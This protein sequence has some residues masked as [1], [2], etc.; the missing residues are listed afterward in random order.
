MKKTLLVIF[1]FFFDN[2]I[3]L[4]WRT[5]KI[6]DDWEE[7]TRTLIFSDTI[8]PNKPLDFPYQNP[9]VYM[10]WDCDMGGFT[11]RNTANNILDT[12]IED[13]YNLIRHDIKIDGKKKSITSYQSW[14]S[15]FIT[16]DWYNNVKLQSATEL[17]VRLN[18]YS[19]GY[20]QYTF[21][22]SNF[23]PINGCN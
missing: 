15:E 11:M 4:E 12:D 13:G 2:S 3:A 20:R 16:L 21:D 17:V 19:D 9:T 6:T 18:H 10:Y 22:L 7:T 23:D 1:L 8:S 14:N 5:E